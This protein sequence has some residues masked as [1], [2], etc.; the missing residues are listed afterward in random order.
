MLRGNHRAKVDEKGRLKIPAAF[1]GELRESGEKGFFVTSLNGLSAR[2]YPMEEW[3]KIEKALTRVGSI[4][5]TK[6]KFLNLANYY[7]QQV[8]L[9]KQ[10]RVLM[11][12]ILR[13]SAAMKGEVDV[14]GMLTCLDVWNH[15][16]YIDDI[17]KNLITADDEKV[18]DELGV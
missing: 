7:G 14:L 18:L 9:D 17:K 5:R 10:G 13:E 15:S 2:I 12:S 4:N 1:L 16:R 6:K 8:R 3:E 11:P